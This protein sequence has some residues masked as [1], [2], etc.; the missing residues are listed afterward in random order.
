MRRILHVIGAMDRGGAETLIM[1]L[2]RV[3]DRDEFQFDFLVHEERDCDYDEEIRDLGGLLY[4]LPRFNG[5]N[6]F[7]YREL[8][9]SFFSEHEEHRVVHG[10]IGS[11]AALYLAEAKR[12]GRYAIAHSHAQ[13]FLRGPAGISFRTVSYPTRFVADYFMA[14]S[15]EA[16]I[17]RFGSAVTQGDRFTV[18]RNGIDLSRYELNH[19]ERAAGRRQWGVEGR[20]VFGHVGRLSEE[21]NHRFLFEVFEEV[22]SQLPDAVLLLA[23]RGPLEGDLRA[24]ACKRGIDDAVRFLGVCEDVPAL[25]KGMDVFVLPSR[26]EGLSMAAIEAQAAGLPVIMSTGVPELAVVSSGV[27]RIPLVEG[28]STWAM[29]CLEAYR[30]SAAKERRAMIDEVRSHGF[31]IAEEAGRLMRF[32]SEAEAN[33]SKS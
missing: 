18:V 6:L 4:R 21:K 19:E 24:E 22:K 9:R 5:V 23:G 30:V 14:C 29:A 3:I 13:N 15:R 31:D 1:N 7:T 11:S 27:Q 28:V 33:I 17:D 25:L 16:G 26:K 2:Y 12:A 32:Y 8:C 10:H 20:P